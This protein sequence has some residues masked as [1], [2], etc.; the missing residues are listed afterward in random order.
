MLSKLIGKPPKER[1]PRRDVGCMPVKRKGELCNA[2][3]L[4]TSEATF[5]ILTGSA[6]AGCM[7]CSLDVNTFPFCAT[8]GMRHS[9]Q[10]TRR[11]LR[12]NGSTTMRK[13]HCLEPGTETLEARSHVQVL[14]A[15]ET[16]LAEEV[17]E[18]VQTAAQRT[19]V[20][21]PKLEMHKSWK[22]AG[23]QVKLRALRKP[24]QRAARRSTQKSGASRS[25]LGGSSN[26]RGPM[27][28][29]NRVQS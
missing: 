27:S 18:A 29:S 22:G 26:Q 12:S 25:H 7:V 17:L 28:T 1:K 9:T 14:R 6:H 16:A 8:T 20:R 5:C 19:E 24:R 4:T 21:I 10:D 11:S 13:K 3:G 15:V 23:E 2:C